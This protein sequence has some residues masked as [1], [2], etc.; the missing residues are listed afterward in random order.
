MTDLEIYKIPTTEDVPPLDEHKLDSRELWSAA[1]YQFAGRFVGSIYDNAMGTGEHSPQKVLHSLQFNWLLEQIPSIQNKLDILLKSLPA[2][3]HPIPSDISALFESADRVSRKTADSRKRKLLKLALVN[4]F[5]KKLYNEG[6][7]L[8]LM[9]I[10][11]N[12]F[13]GDIQF[14]NRLK[15]ES[16]NSYA[17]THYFQET[18]NDQELHHLEMLEKESLV[19]VERG[20]EPYQITVRSLALKLLQLVAE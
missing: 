3:E 2:E 9:E 20:T 11:E 13:Y 4:A 8:R 17:E 14:L 1:I 15:C 7:T 19:R 18:L 6:I 12:L 5:D 16:K 10:L